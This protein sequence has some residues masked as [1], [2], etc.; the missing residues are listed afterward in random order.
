MSKVYGIKYKD[1]TTKILNMPWD[2]AKE[3]VRGV[4]GVVY[5]GFISYVEAEKWL[6]N[7]KITHKD[8]DSSILKIYVDGS[9]VNGSTCAGWGFVAVK[10][11]E[12]IHEEYGA[13]TMY[14]ESRNIAGECFAAIRALRW[15]NRREPAELI[16]DYAGLGAWLTNDWGAKSDIA[17]FYVNACR[18]LIGGVTFVKIGGHSGNVW[19]DRADELARMGGQE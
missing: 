14:V 3:H 12:V 8:V 13:T 4:K 17:I 11:G 16:H 10:N 9:Y 6:N 2:E 5:K 7:K 18:H 15:L 19:N 1:G